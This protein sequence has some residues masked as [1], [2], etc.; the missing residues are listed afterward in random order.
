MQTT[1]HPPMITMPSRPLVAPL[2]EK[3]NRYVT[4]ENTDIRR[5]FEKYRRL[6]ALQKA[7]R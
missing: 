6:L 5:T 3:R 4:A 2:G 7:Q 1:Y